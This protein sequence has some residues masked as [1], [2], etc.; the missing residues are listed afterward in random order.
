[1]VAPAPANCPCSLLLPLLLSF[2]GISIAYH[3]NSRK[4]RRSCAC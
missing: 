2:L 4:I 3:L 1:M